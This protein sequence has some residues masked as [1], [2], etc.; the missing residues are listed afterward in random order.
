M[1]D[2]FCQ[3]SILNFCVV[4]VLPQLSVS[5]SQREFVLRVASRVVGLFDLD[6]LA[7]DDGDSPDTLR[8]INHLRWGLF[9][10]LCNPGILNR[11]KYLRGEFFLE[12]LFLVWAF[13]WRLGMSSAKSRIQAKRPM[14]DKFRHEI[15]PDRLYQ[16]FSL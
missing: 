13:A 3:I 14:G 11:R 2:V 10:Q 5:K 8:S 9:L 15:Q 7:I 6:N 1:R 12:K 16:D 4:C